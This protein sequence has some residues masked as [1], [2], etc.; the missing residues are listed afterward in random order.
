MWNKIKKWYNNTVIPWFKRNWSQ[1]I[2][3]LVLMFVYIQIHSIGTL[4]GTE[5]VLG[6]WLFVLF[7]Y[8]IFWDLLD[9]N[10]MF[11]R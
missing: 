3:I 7:V 8:Y 2:N 1:L 9:M 11:K 10:K 4:P 5:A 6:I